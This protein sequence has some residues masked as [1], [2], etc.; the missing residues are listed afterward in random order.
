MPSRRKHS[1][2]SNGKGGN[3]YFSQSG[4]AVKL[5]FPN[6]S[7]TPSSIHPARIP[8]LTQQSSVKRHK[9][10][11]PRD[12]LHLNDGHIKLILNS[13]NPLPSNTV[14]LEQIFRNFLTLQNFGI[15]AGEPGNTKMSTTHSNIR[16]DLISLYNCALVNRHWCTIA[17]P[18]L[19]SRPFPFGV[20][21]VKILKTLLIGL[22]KD[23]RRELGDNVCSTHN[24]NSTMEQESTIHF[25]YASFLRY[26][27]YGSMIS[28]VHSWLAS[29]N[30]AEDDDQVKQVTI[31]L[32]NLFQ[33]HDVKLHGLYFDAAFHDM[34]GLELLVGKLEH[35]SL[36][37]DIRELYIRG[38][39]FPLGKFLCQIMHDCQSLASISAEL[40][41]PRNYLETAAI[42]SALFNFIA[43]QNSLT[44]LKIAY[45]TSG[46]RLLLEAIGLHA[47]TLKQIELREINFSGCSSW[48]ALH[49]CVNVEVLNVLDA[50]NL[51]ASMCTPSSLAKIPGLKE[52]MI[53]I[54]ARE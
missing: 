37:T 13:Q 38:E 18:L 40:P 42:N 54:K 43:L 30:F 17:V 50:N 1:L 36:I 12:N 52:G 11:P 47:S 23:Q 26:L 34:S 20:N 15:V 16:E 9:R 48:M 3:P 7:S 51:T 35:R 44:T 49:N 24:T 45:V 27:D 41:N 32:L 8:H 29:N 28:A 5:R 10:L 19:W 46:A 31:A 6:T 25:E 14:L 33:Q 22:N 39:D 21:H 4:R 53:T 2:R